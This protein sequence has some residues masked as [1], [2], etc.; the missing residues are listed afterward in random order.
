MICVLTVMHIYEQSRR[1]DIDMAITGKER[2]QITAFHA[3]Y[4]RFR[5]AEKRR[6]REEDFAEALVMTSDDVMQDLY[7]E[8]VSQW[9]QE[10]DKRGRRRVES[11]LRVD[12]PI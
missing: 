10:Y 3:I 9:L 12:K 5:R 1:K 8:L 11:A 4:K 7:P 2:M 6:S